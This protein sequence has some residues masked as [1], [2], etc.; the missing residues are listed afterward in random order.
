MS[1]KYVIGDATKPIITEK[2][3]HIIAHCCNNVGAW[4]RGFVL[5]VSALSPLPKERYKAWYNGQIDA[6]FELGMVQIVRIPDSNLYVSNMIG[7]NNIRCKPDFAGTITPPIRYD[8]LET[9]L[10]KTAAWAIRHDADIHAPRIGCG[11]AGGSWNV[12][13]EILERTSADF[14]VDIYIY[15]LSNADQE[16]YLLQEKE[17]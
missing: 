17:S 13:E 14:S 2:S 10:R 1:V 9:C 4:G 12:V 7:Q 16:K 8:A 15:D 3:Q 6:K 5:A 11:L